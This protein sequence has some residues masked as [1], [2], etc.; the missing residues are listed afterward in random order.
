MYVCKVKT[1]LYIYVMIIL[2]D[3]D[4]FGRKMKDGVGI[5]QNFKEK[6]RKIIQ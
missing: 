6:K 3:T 4:S 1:S 2:N 5:G